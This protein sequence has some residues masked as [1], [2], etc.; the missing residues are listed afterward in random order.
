MPRHRGF[1]RADIASEPSTAARWYGR[2]VLVLAGV[3]AW[4]IAVNAP[5]PPAACPLADD[6]AAALATLVPEATVRTGVDAGADG[7]VLTIASAPT[8]VHVVLVDPAGASVLVR[9]LPAAGTCPELA[10]SVALVVERYLSELGVA[11]ADV[12]IDDRAAEVRR[13]DPDDHSPRMPVSPGPPVVV[14]ELTA[15][16]ALAIGALGPGLAAGAAVGGRQLGLAV[17]VGASWARAEPIERAGGEA[18]GELE[19]WSLHVLAGLAVRRG[20]VRATGW[21]GGERVAA[22]AAGTAV[23]QRIDQA[24]WQALVRAD[25]ALDVP[26]TR[27]L[28]LRLAA[29]LEVRPAPVEV[30]IEGATDS[31]ASPRLGAVLAAGVA[32]RFP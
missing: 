22:A 11:P 13:M 9:D 2:R 29:G 5:A 3:A 23:F 28:A 7:L 24:G 21:L 12:A 25:L 32:W 8:T 16:A 26:V 30:R 4:T 1:T 15:R 14:A 31:Y 27:R 10:E 17:E 19:R 20:R 18:I 6:V